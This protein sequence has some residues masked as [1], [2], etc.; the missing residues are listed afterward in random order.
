MLFRSLFGKGL[1]ITK[2]DLRDEGIKCISYGEVHSKYP[3]GFDSRKD[4]LKCVDT[5]YLKTN[6]QSILSLG[7][8]IFADTSEDIPGSGDFSMNEGE[9]V[10]AG[11]HSIIVRK[12]D[13]RVLNRYLQHLFFSDYW[14]SQIRSTVVG[15][16]VYSISQKI[17]KNCWYLIPSVQEQNE[18]CSYIDSKMVA[19]ALLLKNKIEKIEKLQEYKK[20]LIYEYVTGKK[21]LM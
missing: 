5:S 8:F 1:T 20:S 19:I 2:E 13:E 10:F 7:D 15:I 4:N 3:V 9:N 17:L 6:P 14:R 16:K 12:N 18:I 11:Y 21:Q